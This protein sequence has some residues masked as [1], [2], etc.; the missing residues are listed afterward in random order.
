MAQRRMGDR[1]TMRELGKCENH[2]EYVTRLRRWG[3][4]MR[5]VGGGDEDAA[6]G[7]AA[8]SGAV[9]GAALEEGRGPEEKRFARGKGG[10]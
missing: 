6:T 3:P 8:P 4:M 2:T 10:P 7:A 5:P 9:A 1:V